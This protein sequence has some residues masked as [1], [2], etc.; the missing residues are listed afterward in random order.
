MVNTIEANCL[1]RNDAAIIMIF[2]E[3][4]A[5]WEGQFAP[6]PKVTAVDTTGAKDTFTGT[7]AAHL[8]EGSDRRGA[9]QSAVDAATQ[10]V[11]SAGA[12]RWA[13]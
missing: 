7:L 8:V 6:A 5:L 9:L 3:Q 1:G 13:T 12:Q 10:S 2:G 11:T 4:G